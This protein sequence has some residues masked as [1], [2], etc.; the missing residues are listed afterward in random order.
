M[1]RTMHWT[2]Q[3]APILLDQMSDGCV[4]VDP[5]GT[6]VFWSGGAAALFGF[7]VAEATGRNLIDLIIPGEEVATARASLEAAG[8]GGE[9]SE[10]A[11]TLRRS[12]GSLIATDVTTKAISLPTQRKLVLVVLRDVTERK[13]VEHEM[14]L[15]RQAAEA[16]N[17]LKSEFVANMSHELRTPLNGII[18]FSELLYDGKAGPLKHVHRDYVGY[19]LS[20]SRHLLQL[21]ND[22]LDLAKIEAG[23]LTF[24][25]EMVDPGQLAGEVRDSLRPLVAAKR[26]DVRLEVDERLGLVES[27]GARLKQVLYNYL[28]NA[29]K[30][31]PD[32][33]RVTLRIHPEGADAFRVTVEDTGIGVQ[34]EEM[35]RLFVEFQQLDAGAARQYQG[36]GLGLAVTKRLVEAQGGSVSVQSTFGSGSTFSATLP[37]RS[38]AGAR[39]L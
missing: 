32:G 14:L 6:I 20:S 36:S 29:I 35:R 30:F 3:L 23:Q 37:R 26:L 39:L 19:I 2:E 38:D 25:S 9:I 7:S 18:G 22:I 27:D 12:D 11:V 21:I 31:T 13:R 33:G 28:S 24:T 5:D 15:A 4:V 10:Q 16:A 1:T 17:R 8:R 34:P